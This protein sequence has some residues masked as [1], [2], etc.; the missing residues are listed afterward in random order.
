MPSRRWTAA[1]LERL[2]KLYPDHTASECAAMLGRSIRAVYNAVRHAGLEAQRRRTV[3][4]SVLDRIRQRNGEGVCDTEIAAELGCDRHTVARHRK[5]LGLPS[6][7]YGQQYRA[8]RRAAARRQCEQWGVSSIGE[9][10]SLVFRI[11][12]LRAGWPPDLRARHVEILGLLEARGPMT[13]REIAESLGLPWRGSCR[14]LKSR[15][16]EGSYLAHLM[17][18]GLVISLG[19]VV[20]GRGKGHSVNL[21]DLAIGTQRR[22]S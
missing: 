6:H 9:L 13:R 8:R 2:R 21:Y 4:D 14:S 19:R 12:S 1:E 7:A 17:A 11:R 3:D 15:D 18:R 5:R 10:R 16:P 22:M 20:R